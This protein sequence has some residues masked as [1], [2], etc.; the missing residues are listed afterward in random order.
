MYCPREG[1]EDH[2]YGLTS[3]S[4]LSKEFVSLLTGMW[5]LKVTRSISM[6]KIHEKDTNPAFCPRLV[7]VGLDPCGS[8]PVN[9]GSDFLFEQE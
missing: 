5:S 8:D 1:R 3:P 2:G 9:E 4:Q 6:M 7:D